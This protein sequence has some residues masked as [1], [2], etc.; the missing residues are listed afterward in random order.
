MCCMSWGTPGSVRAMIWN[1]TPNWR[2]KA[3]ILQQIAALPRRSVL[4]AE[5]E[6][7]LLLFPPLRSCWAKRG[8]PRLVTLSGR[9]ARRV[10]FGAINLRTGQRLLEE[11]D[12]HCQEDFQAF[13]DLIGWHYRSWHVGLL[14]DEQGGHI[15]EDTAVLAEQ[16]DIELIGL[17]K[18]TPKLNPMDH[19]WGHAKEEVSANLQYGTIEQHVACF[20]AY[21]EG[22][23]PRE[24]LRKAGVLSENFWLKDVV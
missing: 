4:L 15:A 14:V 17:P 24:A 20:L 23:S 13:L 10:I 19:L 6:T 9:N 18:R 1:R 8:H 12:R 11:R 2:K 5:D 16:L 7:D 21:I 3:Q 22:L